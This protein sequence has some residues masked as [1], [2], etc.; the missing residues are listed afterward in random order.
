MHH[1]GATRRGMAKVCSTSFGGLKIESVVTERQRTTLHRH[2][3]RSAAADWIPRRPAAE[4][5]SPPRS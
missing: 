5:E 1:P 4:I 3:P 2:R